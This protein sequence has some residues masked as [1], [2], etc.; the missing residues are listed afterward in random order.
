MY[1][2][3][4]NF[5][6]SPI[7]LIESLSRVM[8]LESDDDAVFKIDSNLTAHCIAKINYFNPSD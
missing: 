1:G 8:T 2:L 5:Q 4:F 7:L 3:Q 6:S